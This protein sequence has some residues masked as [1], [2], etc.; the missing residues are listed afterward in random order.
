MPT[1]HELMNRGWERL[2][3]YLDVSVRKAKGLRQELQNAGIVFYI[4]SGRPPQK[5]VCWF[6][7]DVRR[8]LQWK[9]AHREVI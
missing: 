4:K 6:A 8:W 3:K 5:S 1:E 7:S 2:A 9:G